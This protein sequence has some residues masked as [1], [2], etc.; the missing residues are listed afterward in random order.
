MDA[1]TPSSL[2]VKVGDT[3]PTVTLGPVTRAMLALYAGASGDHNAIH[4]DID[5]ARQ[6]GVP[7]VFAHGMLSFGV[8]AQVPTR[9]AGIARLR[10]MEARFASVVQVHD[11]I[12]CTGTI[13]AI[14][15]QGAGPAAR[16]ALIASAQDGR[17]VLTGEAIV[18]LA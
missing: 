11:E 7:D 1:P 8:L 5:V 14:E 6:A 10:R 13:T 4:I 16:I 12:T 9:W 15:D 18:S 3:L 2:E 17:Q